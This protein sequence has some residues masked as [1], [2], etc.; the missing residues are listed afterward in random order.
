MTPLLGALTTFAE[1]ERA[2]LAL[3]EAAEGHGVPV[4]VDSGA[5]SVFT[6][7]AKIG[8]R[9][10]SQFV[11]EA[12]ARF[13]AGRY[14]GLDVIGDAEQTLSNWRSQREEGIAVE[15]TIH[16]GTDPALA[17]GYVGL[18]AGEWVNFGGLVRYQK[19]S[20][21]RRLAAWCAAVRRELP[22]EVRIHG[23][24][25]VTPALN[26]LFPFD[27]VDSTY[28][29]L[30]LIRFRTLSLFNPRTARWVR[31]RVNSRNRH[32]HQEAWAETHRYGRW[33][34]EE[35]GVEPAFLLESDDRELV[36]LSVESTRR[37]VEYYRE[38]HGRGLVA[39]LAAVGIEDLPLLPR[40]VQGA[41]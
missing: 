34:R 25:C 40:Q 9:E 4:I 32:W 6:G 2:P 33:L 22:E 16:Y 41:A 13:P 15:P 37:F 8:L 14:I 39:Y 12:S 24:G 3:L 36:A 5:W 23:L 38:R 11:R 10:H 19:G 17:R 27:A 35:Y 31:I 18:E 26:H 21:H 28:W 1:G 7:T 30:P 29:K 20:D